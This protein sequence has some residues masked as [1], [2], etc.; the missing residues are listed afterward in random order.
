MFE[1]FKKAKSDVHYW[2]L[3]FFPPCDRIILRG[4]SRVRLTKYPSFFSSKQIV[5]I[6]N[7]FARDP[8]V[9]FK[10]SSC[11]RLVKFKIFSQ[12]SNQKFHDFLPWRWPTGDFYNIVKWLTIAYCDICQQ[13]VDEF[14]NIFPRPTDE[15]L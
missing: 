10:I 8:L 2:N 12:H 15:F 7:L 11:N 6:H 4:F 14:H 13:P 3:R 5:E 9:N 1:S